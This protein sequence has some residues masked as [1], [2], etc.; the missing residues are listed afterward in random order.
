MPVGTAGA[1]KALSW[2]EIEQTQ[3]TLVLGNTYHL[4]LR[5]GTSILQ[6]AGGLHRFTGWK[7][8]LLTD[9]GGYQ[10]FSLAQ[11]R[12]ITEEGVKFQSHIDGTPYMFTPELVVDMQREI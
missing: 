2:Q 11:R 6:E 8:P 12:K 10:V 5:P 1:V 9:S 4:F 7:G 3:A